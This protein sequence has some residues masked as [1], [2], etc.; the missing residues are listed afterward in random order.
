MHNFE[1]HIPEVENPENL[2]IQEKKE[3][4]NLREKFP[5]QTAKLNYEK[6]SNS[7]DTYANFTRILLEDFWVTQKNVQFNLPDIQFS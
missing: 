1:N 6:A 3:N 7:A 4:T 2:K 5:E